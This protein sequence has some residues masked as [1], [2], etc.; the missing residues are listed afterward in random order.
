MTPNRQKYSEVTAR[1]AAVNLGL[2]NT[3]RSSI[4]VRR[5][6]STPTK[7][8]STVSE[9]AKATRTTG[10]VHPRLGPS[11][12]AYTSAESPTMD[13]SAPGGSSGAWAASRDVGTRNTPATSATAQTGTFTQN[14]DPQ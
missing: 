10:L 3:R 14:T 8:A 13:S 7:P 9:A 1:L 6:S 11:M 5:C 2:V 4:G 12:M